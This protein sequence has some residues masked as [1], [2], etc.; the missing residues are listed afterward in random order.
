MDCEFLLNWS[1]KPNYLILLHDWCQ[2]HSNKIMRVH[3]Y[4]FKWKSLEMRNTYKSRNQIQSLLSLFPAGTW[5]LTD[6]GATWLRRT[7]VS[8][9]SYRCHVP[10]GS[11]NSNVVSKAVYAPRTDLKYIEISACFSAVI[12]KGVN[13]CDFPFTSR[14]YKPFHIVVYSLK[15]LCL[16]L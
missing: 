12:T 4:R 11:Y 16:C 3:N 10:L 2:K 6:V 8:V 14:D 5:R 15:M 1:L 13:F 9:T 7:N